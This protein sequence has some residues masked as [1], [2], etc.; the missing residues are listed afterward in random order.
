MTST[1]NMTNQIETSDSVLGDD[2][3][4]TASKVPFYHKGVTTDAE[5]SG[6]LGT[7]VY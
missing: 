4:G 2:K 6:M 7:S 1:P 5:H 3:L